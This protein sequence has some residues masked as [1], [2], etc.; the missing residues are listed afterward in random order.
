MT[1]YDQPVLV[2]E[3]NPEYF[4]PGGKL[5]CPGLFWDQVDDMETAETLTLKCLIARKI[6]IHGPP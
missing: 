6:Y 4:L 2:W 3:V 5:N 1:E